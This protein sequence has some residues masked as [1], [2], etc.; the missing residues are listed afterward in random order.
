MNKIVKKSISL[1][2][3]LTIFIFMLTA[4]EKDEQHDSVDIQTEDKNEIK[5]DEGNAK[6]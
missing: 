1:M 2:I 5:I 6:V 4:C 3:I